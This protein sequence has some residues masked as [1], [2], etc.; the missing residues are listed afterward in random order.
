MTPLAPDPL[1]LIAGAFGLPLALVSRGYVLEML[2][3]MRG[4]PL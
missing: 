3:C 1:D 2:R 4:E